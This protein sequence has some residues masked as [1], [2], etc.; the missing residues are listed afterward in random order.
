MFIP[1]DDGRWV[2]E[3]FARLAEVVHDYD[4]MYELRWIPPEHRS[5]P[6]DIQNCYAV[7]EVNPFGEFVVFYAGPHNTAEEILTAL[8]MGDNK[9][10]NVLDRID[11]HNNA[12]RAMKLKQE[13]DEAEER[14]DYMAWLIGTKQ[15]YIRLSGGRVVDDQLRPISKK[16][17]RR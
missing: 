16:R 5:T 15:N 6:D 1:T 10:G 8:F 9:H 3:N 17:R 11:A 2:D 4:P 7:V 14:K 13:M 12:V